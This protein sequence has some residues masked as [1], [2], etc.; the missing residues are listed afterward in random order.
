[1]A[2][3]N[4]EKLLERA[5]SQ[6]PPGAF[7]FDRFEIP[8]PICSVVGNRTLVTNFKEI[9]DRLRRDQTHL[10]RFLARELATAGTIEGTRAVF[11]G[12]FGSIII[13]R[14]IERYVQEF[15]RCTV[16]G[17]PDTKIVREDRIHFM[18]C[19]ACGARSPIHTI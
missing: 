4:Y 3:T 2:E 11:Q 10:L 14:L 13:E 6:L 15:V 7:K 9:C 8:R 19:E 18:I 1:M 16:C 5:H 17:Q 12:K